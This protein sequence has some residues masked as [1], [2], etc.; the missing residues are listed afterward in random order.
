MVENTNLL[1]TE[2]G[3]SALCNQFIIS[4]GVRNF[5]DGYYLTKKLYS[6]AVFGMASGLLSYADKSY[7]ALEQFVE[8]QI[9]GLKL[10]N[11]YLTINE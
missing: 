7:E 2:L 6:N 1:L 3:E 5:L 11:A 4:G 9:E 10:A 8:A